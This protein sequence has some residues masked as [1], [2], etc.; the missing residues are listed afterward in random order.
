MASKGEKSRNEYYSNI[1]AVLSFNVFFAIICVIIYLFWACYPMLNTIYEDT[2]YSLPWFLIFLISLN[3]LLPILLLWVMS[4][5][6]YTSRAD[7]YFLTTIIMLFINGLIL[8]GF[9]IDWLSRL[10]NTDIPGFNPFNDYRW[11]CVYYKNNPELCSNNVFNLCIPSVADSDL[12]VNY[13][14]ILH[15]IMVGV[16]FIL[17]LAH[18]LVHTNLHQTGLVRND[19]KTKDDGLIFGLVFTFIYAAIFTYWA[20]FPLL[21]TIYINGY[22][23]FAITPSPNTF[24]STLYGFS[25]VIIFFLVL[26]ILPI[27]TFLWAAASRKSIFTPKFHYWV[28]V[29]VIYLSL[30]TTIVLLLIWAVD[31]NNMFSGGSICNS[32]DWCG[33]F[34]ANSPTLC[35][36]VTPY[37]VKPKLTVNNEFLQHIIIAA[38]F[39]MFG[40]IYVWLNKRMKEYRVF[41]N[42]VY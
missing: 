17:N 8:F 39:T 11:C 1:N 7:I 41:Y 5:P 26:N 28:T 36:N 4:R 27:A 35:P 21:N 16:F 31:C 30:F 29:F 3:I 18:W 40:T 9:A 23:R 14:F 33:E 20:A 6:Q 42:K 32:Y 2:K 22:P 13:E 12:G 19:L 34:F 15:S 24:E 25:W 10:T 37:S 38:I